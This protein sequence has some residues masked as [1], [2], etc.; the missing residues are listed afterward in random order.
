MVLFSPHL[1]TVSSNAENMIGGYAN[2][3]KCSRGPDTPASTHGKGRK[4]IIHDQA[5]SSTMYMAVSFEKRKVKKVT[6]D[7]GEI[8][9][10]VKRTRK[11]IYHMYIVN[12]IIYTE[13]ILRFVLPMQNR[14]SRQ[15]NPTQALRT[16]QTRPPS[17]AGS[18]PQHMFD[19]CQAMGST[20]ATT[21]CCP[22]TSRPS[23]RL[24]SPG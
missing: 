19:G 1:T 7:K 18:R 24:S 14:V 16:M 20:T 15:F 4:F 12:N 22:P 6:E 8:H 13:K 21:D 23:H 2:S 10:C 17:L 5:Q 9:I 3:N 11:Y